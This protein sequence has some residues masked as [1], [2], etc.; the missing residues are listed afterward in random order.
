MW[1][2]RV[3]HYNIIF[4]NNLKINVVSNNSIN[5]K[6]LKI[7]IRRRILEEINEIQNIGKVELIEI[8]L[9]IYKSPEKIDYY[10]PKDSA[11]SNVINNPGP[12]YSNDYFNLKVVPDQRDNTLHHGKYFI[13]YRQPPPV[14]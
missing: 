11:N 9:K 7:T 13:L 12:S 14:I 2:L 3:P 5:K 8:N 4:V 1:L 6:C 10:S